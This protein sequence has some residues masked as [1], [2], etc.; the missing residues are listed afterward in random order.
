MK[1]EELEKLRQKLAERKE[2]LEKE[3][4]S[5]ATK[6]KKVKDDYDTRFP[7]IGT[8]QSTDE[9]ALRVTTYD[10]SLPMEYALELRLADINKALVKIKKGEYGICENCGQSVEEKRLQAMPEAKLC[11]KCQ[12]K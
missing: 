7:D 5:F 9:A 6:D 1:K 3:L 12:K 11:I 4:A 2:K 8:P 10:S